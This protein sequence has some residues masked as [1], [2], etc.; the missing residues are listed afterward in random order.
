MLRNKGVKIADNLPAG[1]A[2]VDE[3]LQRDVASN[4]KDDI[5]LCKAEAVEEAS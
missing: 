5:R 3:Y 1:W 4:D 2:L